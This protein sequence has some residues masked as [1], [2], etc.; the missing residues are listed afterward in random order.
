[1][2]LIS[3]NL[4][5]S[6]ARLEGE[7]IFKEAQ[8]CFSEMIDPDWSKVDFSNPKTFAAKMTI[9]EGFKKLEG[10]KE[11]VEKLIEEYSCK[12]P[13]S[14]EGLTENEKEELLVKTIEDNR[15]QI[16]LVSDKIIFLILN[17]CGLVD[18]KFSERVNQKVKLIKDFNLRLEINM[19]TSTKSELFS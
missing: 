7:K 3:R 18:G 1:M 15:F 5:S 10:L 2:A 9:E 6:D 12:K 11:K 19:M 14:I 13:L 4:G 8:N 17:E 16:D